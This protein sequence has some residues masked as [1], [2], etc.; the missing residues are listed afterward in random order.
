[1]ESTYNLRRSFLCREKLQ[2]ATRSCQNN[3][4]HHHHPSHDEYD[5]LLAEAVKLGRQHETKAKDFVPKMYDALVKGE[6][7]APFDAADRIYKDL[8][9]I[10]Q[11]DTIRRLLPPESKSQTARDMQALSRFT[12]ESKAGAILREGSS[13]N[14]SGGGGSSEIILPD[15]AA[16][17][18]NQESSSEIVVAAQL[19][20]ENARLRKAIEDLEIT[21]KVLMER[22][23]KL[24]RLLLLAEEGRKQQLQQQLQ[25]QSNQS[26]KGVVAVG[27]EGAGAPTTTTATTT[28]MVM[29]PPHLFMKAFALMR[30]STKPLVLRVVSK[31]AVDIERMSA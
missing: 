24:E 1:M 16:A 23:L 25:Q 18:G 19:E 4:H 11:K 26:E 27:A 5:R 7:L 2:R 17:A 15:V 28:T 29:L 31:E 14:N 8:V 20:Q 9:G 12:L 3:R 30:G 13:N 22:A 21:K 10:W 6:G